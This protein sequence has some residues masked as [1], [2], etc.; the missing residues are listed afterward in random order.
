M[1]IKVISLPSEISCWADEIPGASVSSSLK[2][3]TL[4]PLIKNQLVC[5]AKEIACMRCSVSGTQ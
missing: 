4:L 2:M 5:R 1:H 3:E